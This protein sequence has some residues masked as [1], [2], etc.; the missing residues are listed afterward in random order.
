[1]KRGQ[2]MNHIGYN[3]RKKI[4]YAALKKWGFE[5]QIWM[6]IEEMSELQK[7]I[8]KA[9]RGKR[10]YDA[11]ADEIADV[12]VMLEQLQVIFGLRNLVFKHMDAKITRLKERLTAE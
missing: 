11:L 8:C 12:A 5:A 9:K 10:D 4:Y 1:M 3:E 6:V 2:E 7:E